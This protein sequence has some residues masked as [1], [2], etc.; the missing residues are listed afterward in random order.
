[1]DVAAK[2]AALQ[3]S[4]AELQK[5]QARHGFLRVLGFKGLGFSV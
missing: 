2:T 5:A 3:R 4:Q 1:M